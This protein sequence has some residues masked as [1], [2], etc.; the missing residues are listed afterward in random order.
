MSRTGNAIRNSAYGIG[1][2]AVNL[3]FSFV[4]RTVFIYYLG[5]TYLGINGLYTEILSMLSFAELGIGSALIYAMYEPVARGRELET[6][7]LLD[8]YRT[9]YRI[10]AFAVTLIGLGT[11]P[12]LPYIVKGA[13]ILTVRELRLYYVI[14]LFNTVA[15]YFM[16]Y[17]YSYV[18]A[19]QKNYLV[20]NF[21]TAVN[22]VIVVM[23]IAA[24][25]ITKDFLAY[26]LTHSLCLALSKAIAAVYLDRRF[27][28]LTR[29]PEVPLAKE[30]RRRIFKD[31]KALAAGQLAS[32][33]VHSTDNIIISSFT[34]LG[35]AAVGF[36]SNYMMLINGVLAFVTVLFNSVVSGFGNLAATSSREDYRKAFLEVNFID[37]WVYG[38]CC[39]AFYVLVPPFITLWI[40]GENLIDDVSF[41]LIV[42]NLYLQGQHT[43]YMY[44][45][46]AKGDFRRDI[47]PVILQ[48]IVNL[49]VSVI[50][51]K[52]F[53][54][55]GVYIGTLASRLVITMRPALGYRVFFGRS[56]WEYYRKLAVYFLAAFL[57]GA[58]TLFTVQGLLR[59][60]TWGRFVLAACV[61][62]VLPNGAFLLL[63]FRTQE[64]KNVSYRMRVLV[65]RRL[66]HE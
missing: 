41:L 55:V 50:G 27:P 61:V 13:D 51:A 56:A 47:M 21:D 26:L 24:I 65:E 4:S 12:F 30:E 5:N 53:G 40:G 36:V 11:I 57:V 43:I 7:Q 23:Q 46:A 45:R 19:L 29:K 3:L 28:I 22:A 16:T 14:F 8:L 15:S 38:F 58:V 64:F 33:A 60:L 59:G 63:F 52:V 44:A 10:I 62:A 18:N 2:K 6:V 9:A 1:G 35:V 39:I 34:G 32:V 20:T 31:V 17:K 25:L 54:L 42:I 66:D 37:F 48:P 49:V